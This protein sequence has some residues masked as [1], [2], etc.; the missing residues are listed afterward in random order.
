MTS[1]SAFDFSPKHSEIVS[2]TDSNLENSQEQRAFLLPFKISESFQFYSEQDV[3]PLYNPVTF[4]P[5]FGRP[6]TV[7]KDV[8]AYHSLY[9]SIRK[10]LLK[11]QVFPF[12]SF[13]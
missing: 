8:K 13:W 12:H 11:S 1:A 6:E 7:F 2:Q 9:H 5:K 10:K 4:D 3:K